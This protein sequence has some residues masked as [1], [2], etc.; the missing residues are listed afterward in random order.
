MAMTLLHHLLINQWR[1][2][3]NQV[4]MDYMHWAN[5]GTKFIGR[6]TR[7]LFKGIKTYRGYQI[8]YQKK[9]GSSN[10]REA[11]Q[12]N[13]ALMRCYPIAIYGLTHD[14]FLKVAETDCRL[15]NPSSVAIATE[16]RYLTSLVK[17]LKGGDKSEI[18]GDYDLT[19]VPDVRINKG[20][21]THALYCSYYGLTQY[22]N[23]HDAIKNIIMLGGDT[24]TN[25]EIAGG[26]LGAYYGIEDMN[27]NC[28]FTNNL[29]M[30][31]QREIQAGDYP[32][33][34]EYAPNQII[35]FL[36]ELQSKVK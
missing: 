7:E 12:S 22:D 31:M 13:G 17:A 28:E 35:Q 33:P 1:Y 19:Q 14:D 20:L 27:Q 29:A 21:C 6:N 8:R 3:P 10:E 15:T 25:A 30:V 26:L 36:Q 34:P 16:Q 5:S 32:R 2:D 9:F 24:D 18:V 4:V 11:S 23:Y